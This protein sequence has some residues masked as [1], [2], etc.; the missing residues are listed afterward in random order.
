M[1]PEGHVEKRA[2]CASGKEIPATMQCIVCHA[3]G[4]C[5]KEAVAHV[6]S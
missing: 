5:V 2:M 4:E 6:T 1:R 3:P